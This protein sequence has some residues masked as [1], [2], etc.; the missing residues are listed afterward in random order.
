MHRMLA[1]SR[2]QNLVGGLP[3]PRSIGG[4]APPLSDTR[5]QIDSA[6]VFF[7]GRPDITSGAMGFWHPSGTVAGTNPQANELTI[8]PRMLFPAYL[9]F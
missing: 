9:R 2:R 7:T 8:L 1:P 6:L 5:A 4:E 3:P